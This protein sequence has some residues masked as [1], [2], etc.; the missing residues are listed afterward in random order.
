MLFYVPLESEG[1]LK[2]ALGRTL[3]DLPYILG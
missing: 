2:S 1:T 3:A